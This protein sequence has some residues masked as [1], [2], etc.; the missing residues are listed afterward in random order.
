ME[1]VMTSS[2]VAPPPSPQP[3]WLVIGHKKGRSSSQEIHGQ[4]SE[5]GQEQDGHRSA[6]P[7]RRLSSPSPLPPTS[8]KPFKKRLRPQMER[9]FFPFELQKRAT[10]FASTSGARSQIFYICY[11][12]PTHFFFYESLVFTVRREASGRRS[13]PL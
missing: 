4:K 2:A 10:R 13:P 5:S 3:P 6:R 7:V 12:P 9:I 11:S 1:C 8:S